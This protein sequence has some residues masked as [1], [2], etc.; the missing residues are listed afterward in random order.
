LA[1]LTQSRG[2]ALALVAS[3]ALLLI[4][5][6]GRLT[7]AWSLVVI[8]GG[9]AFSVPALRD[10]FNVPGVAPT[11]DTLRSVA[12]A[13]LAGGLVAGM[14]WTLGCFVTATFARQTASSRRTMRR[15]SATGI[16]LVA[17]IG[18]ATVFSNPGQR[19][20]QVQNQYET[21]TSLQPTDESS[22]LTSG[23]G[24]RYDYWRV[25]VKQL[26]DHP[27]TGVGA[28]NYNSTYY[29]ERTTSEDI[30]QAHS[31]QLQALGEL[32][33]IGGL[34]LA[35]FVGAVLLG[36]WQTARGSYPHRANPALAVAAG[37]TFLV[38][39]FQTSVDWMHLIPGLTGI[40]ICAA[41]VL[42]PPVRSLNRRA[43]T[44]AIVMVAAVA[45][46][47]AY[48]V[49]NQLLALRLQER[50]SEKL[51]S[52]P[53]GSLSDAQG[54]LSLQPAQRTYYLKS[55]GFARLG[56]YGPARETLRAA[57]RRVPHDFVAWGL[58]GDLATR[59]GLDDDARRYYE[60]ASE[61][62]PRDP[63]LAA[64]AQGE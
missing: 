1:V 23:G 20:E 18:F 4:I 41:A 8:M 35:A 39:L 16:T 14:I 34:A 53:V 5:V 21:F 37:G 52:D 24:N 63:G 2:A 29:Q 13:S 25:A 32:G 33:L 10:A 7:R 12:E 9:V 58:L 27:L 15:V 6:P 50:A 47:V 51:R 48:P 60:R 64:L 11:G 44:V 30:Q 56:L 61:L 57:T 42:L 3:G 55:A 40:A 49:A 38:W 19:V 31:I 59:R 62:N 22:R 17:L 26:E 36:F 54:S 45:G 43:P 28:G 46:L